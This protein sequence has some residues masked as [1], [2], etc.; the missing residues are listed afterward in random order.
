MPKRYL[1]NIT[2]T[3]QFKGKEEPSCAFEYERI[4][5]TITLLSTRNASECIFHR[6]C[7]PG[8][9]KP[10]PRRFHPYDSTSAASTTI[11]QL[12][13]REAACLHLASSHACGHGRAPAFAVEKCLARKDYTRAEIAAST[14]AMRK[15]GVTG[16]N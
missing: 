9:W 15:W 16:F 2:S 1:A 14:V 3:I 10:S 13:G 7:G 6:V 12:H 11:L 8:N 5:E 4:M